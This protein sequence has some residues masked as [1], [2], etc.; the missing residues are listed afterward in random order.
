MRRRTFIQTSLAACAF[1]T[2]GPGSELM[3][4]ET[5]SVEVINSGVGGNNTRDLLARLDQDCLALQPDL[6]ILMIGTNDMN[7]RK[8][9]P[10]LEFGKNLRTIIEQILR[11]KGEL[12]LMNLLPV[13]EPY[14]L[15]RHNPEFYLPEGHSGRLKEM[16]RCI[17]N[18]AKEY[19]LKWLDL[20][21]IFDKI[22]NIGL[23]PSSLIKNE[24][25]SNTTDGLHP[26]PEG[27]RII[28]LAV[29]QQILY[30][31]LKVAK[32]VCLGDSI[33]YGDGSMNKD[34]Y[35]GWLKKLIN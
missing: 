2:P 21:H 24:A 3:A 12:L 32:I 16:N 22:G 35:P 20:Y 19:K 33:T 10:M 27:Y 30:Y 4:R 5:N 1:S 31:K 9:V 11:L 8:F 7:S 25:N 6:T 26:T 13:Y 14:L 29:Y 28:G 17:E 18:T 15:T 34:S 23:E